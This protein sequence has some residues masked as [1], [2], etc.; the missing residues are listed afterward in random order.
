MAWLFHLDSV[1]NWAYMDS[2]FTEEECE[3][4]KRICLSKNKETASVISNDMTNILN[5][6]IRKNSVVWINEDKDLHWMYSRLANVAMNLNNQ[7]FNFDLFGFCENIQFTEYTAPDEFYG[8]HMDKVL[9]GVSR[10]LSLVVQLTNPEEYEGGDLVFNI[11]GEPKTVQKTQ[12]TV[13]AFPSY[14]MHQ[15]KP[16][17]KGIR[18]SLVAWIAGPNFK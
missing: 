16:V 12:G 9:N 1:E 13:F 2:V 3:K 7:F 11:G 15:V 17:T 14:I 4:I 8:E 18:H 6:E 10:K 5:H